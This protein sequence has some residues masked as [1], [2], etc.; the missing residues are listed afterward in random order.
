ARPLPD[1]SGEKRRD[2]PRRDAIP[3]PPAAFLELSAAAAAAPADRRAGA[4][5][6]GTFRFYFGARLGGM[7]I[8]VILLGQM[9]SAAGK[10]RI[11]LRLTVDGLHFAQGRIADCACNHAG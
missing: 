3:Y 4:A 6:A 10:I 8:P 7:G 11:G 2:G 5:A 1:G 9:Q